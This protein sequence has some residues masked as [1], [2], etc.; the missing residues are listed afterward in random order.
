MPVYITDY[1]K[2]SFSIVLAQDATGDL[3]KV[4][5]FYYINTLMDTPHASQE[6]ESNF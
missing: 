1:R 6:I 5:S 3:Q 2:G 4:S